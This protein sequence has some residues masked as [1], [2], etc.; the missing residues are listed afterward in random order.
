MPICEFCYKETTTDNIPESWDLVWQSAVC[1]ECKSRV[2]ADGGYFVVA[3][4]SYA[5]GKSDPRDRTLL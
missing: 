1:P 3:G 5:N 4:G 2:Q